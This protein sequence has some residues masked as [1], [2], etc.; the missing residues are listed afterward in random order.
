MNQKLSS[1]VWRLAPSHKERCSVGLQVTELQAIGMNG[2]IERTGGLLTAFQPSVSPME[3]GLVAEAAPQLAHCDV[4]MPAPFSMIR[5]QA[6][7]QQVVPPPV[8]TSAASAV[9]KL[10]VALS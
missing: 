6:A 7:V 2:A 5:A 9:A 4:M 8:L 3:K 10:N 1:T